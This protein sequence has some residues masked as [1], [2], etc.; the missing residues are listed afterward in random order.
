MGWFH[1]KKIGLVGRELKWAQVFR[2]FFSKRLCDVCNRKLRAT[3][4]N[5]ESLELQLKQLFRFEWLRASEC[6]E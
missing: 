1:W 4:H 3:A 5:H 6:H 2:E